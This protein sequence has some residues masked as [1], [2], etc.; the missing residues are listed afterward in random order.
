MKKIIIVLGSALLTVFLTLFFFLTPTQVITKI[1]DAQ[2]TVVFN[3]GQS[4]GNFLTGFLFTNVSLAGKKGTKLLILDEVTLDLNLLPLFL[5]RIGMDIH[6]KGITAAISAGFD[7]SIDGV[8]SFTGVP[9]DTSTFISPAN[10]SFTAPVSGRVIASGRKADIEV[11]ADE[12]TWERLSVSG[13]ELPRDIFEKGKGGISVERGRIIVKSIA[14]EGGKGYA[15]LSG[16]I[17]NRQRRLTLELFPNEWDDFML[18]PFERYKISPGQY[19]MPV[20]F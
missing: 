11:R 5:G 15:R 20:D 17:I 16:E 1:N 2:Q 4:D 18:I 8:A 7:G 14:F 10:L 19:K 9:L 6:S 12:I 13:F 3:A